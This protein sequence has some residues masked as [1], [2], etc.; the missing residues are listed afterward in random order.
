M[1]TP[2]KRI[3]KDFLLK[4]LYD[5]QIP[6]MYIKGQT[7]YVLTESLSQ[8][9]RSIR[10]R[11]YRLGGGRLEADGCV[12]FMTRF[13]G[14]DE[15]ITGELFIRFEEGNW[16]LD[17]LILEEKRAISEIRDGYRYNFSPYERFY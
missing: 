2:I 16:I 14:Q 17:D 15:S 13:I 4:A 3:E 6:V 1:A 11:S 12:S 10:P 7:Q 9:I 8:E 5:E